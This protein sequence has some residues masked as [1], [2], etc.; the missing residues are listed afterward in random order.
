M[1]ISKVKLIDSGLK[2]IEV[3][4]LKQEVKGG[5]TFQ[6]EYMK[7]DKRPVTKELRKLFSRLVGDGIQIL[8]LN[9]KA[10]FTVT[11][12]IG[13]ENQFQITGKVMVLDG[14]VYGLATPVI[15]EGEYE[16]YKQVMEIIDQIYT[17]VKEHLDSDKTVTPHQ[18]VMDFNETLHGEKKLTKEEIDSMDE[19]EKTKYMMDYLEKK[20]AVIMAAEDI[21]SE[22]APQED[23]N[24]PDEEPKLR[25]VS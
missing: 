10:D 11:G 12:V 18:F 15:K 7:K 2:G 4:F 1:K 6:N 14:K 22:P 19:S 17:G 23:D 20:G 16:H 13:G 25:K 8:D 21:D 3:S 24:F 5:L 9:Q